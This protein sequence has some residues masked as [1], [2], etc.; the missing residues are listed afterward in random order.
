MKNEENQLFELA[1]V[2]EFGN[3]A[4]KRLSTALSYFKLLGTKDKSLNEINSE[5]Y[6]LGCNFNLVQNNEKTQISLTGLSDNFEPA[7]KL[8]MEV[9]FSAVP[10]DAAYKN[11]VDDILKSRA[12]A[13]L[14]KNVIMRSGLMNYGMYG[15]ENPLTQQISESEL[16][17]TNPSDLINLIN[18]LRKYQHK[19]TYYGPL[20]NDAFRKTVG[21]YY[22]TKD[23]PIPPPLNKVYEE[24]PTDENQ[25]YFVNYKMKQVEITFINRSDFFSV[26]NLPIINLYNEYFGGGM[27]AIVFQELREAKALAY[28]VS[29]VYRNPDSKDKH[30]YV[31]SYI[32]TQSDKLGE[33]LTGF[34]ELL[35]NMPMSDI[36]FNSAKDGVIKSIE[37]ER[38]LRSAVITSYLNNKR[39]GVDYDLR[40][41]VYNKVKN[42]NLNDVK[43]FNEKY[44]KGKKYVYLVI[45]D[46]SKLDF[47]ILEKY[48]KVQELTLEQLFGY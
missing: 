9:L 5:F 4:D 27:S 37:T 19:V 40:K 25:V 45:G 36:T 41:D 8:M 42:Y 21:K 20:D 1:L 15:A 7:L 14:S 32:G 33:A 12:N 47:S 10:D 35:N 44:V 38:V 24:L 26:D 46:K 6:R 18:S 23:M 34:D 30:H 11:L 3:N 43:A 17:G 29:S 31:Y 39:L 2:Y 48:G 13:K 16:K 28:S 22:L